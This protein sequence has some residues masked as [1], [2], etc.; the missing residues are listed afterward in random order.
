MCRWVK[1]KPVYDNVLDVC[2]RD[3]ENIESEGLQKQ[4]VYNIQT[5]LKA[6]TFPNRMCS[7][8]TDSSSAQGPKYHRDA[9]V[10]SR[11]L[12]ATVCMKLE[13]KLQN[14]TE[15]HNRHDGTLNSK[16][17]TLNKLYDG[18]RICRR[19]TYCFEHCCFDFC[20]SDN[21][22][23]SWLKKFEYNNEHHKNLKYFSKA[24]RRHYLEIHEQFNFYPKYHHCRFNQTHSKFKHCVVCQF[25]WQQFAAEK[26]SCADKTARKARHSIHIY[27]SDYPKTLCVSPSYPIYPKN[28]NSDRTE[29]RTPSKDRRHSEHWNLKRI[30][31]SPKQPP[32]GNL[33]IPHSFP[34]PVVSNGF[35]SNPNP[36][37]AHKPAITCA[38]TRSTESKIKRFSKF[39]DIQKNAR[40]QIREN[41]HSI[42][43]NRFKIQ[44]GKGNG[45]IGKGSLL[46][47]N[48][49]LHE[50][51]ET[52]PKNRSHIHELSKAMLKSAQHLLLSPPSHFCPFE[53]YTPRYS[54]GNS[55]DPGHQ[56]TNAKIKFCNG[57]MNKVKIATINIRGFKE[58]E[59][60][61][62]VMNCMDK[63]QIDI[64][65]LQ[66][67]YV[68][69]NSKMKR[70]KYTFFH[71]TDV[72]DEDRTR[73]KQIMGKGK[74]QRKGQHRLGNQ[75]DQERHGVAFIVKNSI[76]PIIEDITQIDG[77]NISIKIRDHH[78]KI[79][80]V[81][82]YAPH[83]GYELEVKEKH[84]Q[85]LHNIVKHENAH[86]KIIILGDF[87]VRLQGQ[88]ETE[89]HIIG[90]NIYGYGPQHISLCKTQVLESRELFISFCDEHNMIVSNTFTNQNN[91]HI[92]TYTDPSGERAQLDYILINNKWANSLKNIW[93]DQ[94]A[95]IYSDHKPIIATLHTKLA[96]PKTKVPFTR[97]KP[98]DNEQTENYNK[99]IQ[100]NS[101][102]IDWTDHVQVMN[103]LSD[104]AENSF[105][106][107][108]P[109]IKKSYIT[110]STWE[111]IQKRQRIHEQKEEGDGKEIVKQVKKAVRQDRTKFVIDKL[112][113]TNKKNPNWKPIKE[114]RTDYTPN[115]TK[116]MDKNGKR[117]PTNNR[118]NAIADYL[119][120][121]HWKSKDVPPNYDESP[122]HNK[123]LI[124]ETGPY[125]TAELEIVLQKT[126]GKKAP[127]PDNIQ[128]E[129]IKALKEEGREQLLILLNK[130]HENKKI[131][132][133]L[134]KATVVSIFKKGDTAK[135]ENYRPIS[136]LNTIY[137]IYSA[138][139][140]NRLENTL[141][142]II[143]KT[144]FGF[145]K[146][147]SC[148]HALH[149]I[150]RVIDYGEMSNLNII[151]IFLDW[152]KAFDKV[153]HKRLL[154]ALK[155]LN[156]PGCYLEIITN[157]YENPTFQAKYED[158]TSEYKKQEAGIRQGCT[159]SPYLFILLMTVLMHDVNKNTHKKSNKNNEHGLNENA[160]LFADDT[161]L[162]ATSTIAAKALLHEV[163]YQSE[164]YGLNL[165]KQKCVYFA[166]NKNNNINFLDGEELRHSENVTYLGAKLTKNADVKEEITTRLQK[167]NATWHKLKLFWKN[168]DCTTSWKIQVYNSVIKSKLLYGLETTHVTKAQMDRLTA[169]HTKGLRNI[170][171]L[172][173]TFMDRNNTKKLIWDKANQA[174]KNENPNAPNIETM[175]ETLG[176][177]RIKFIGHILRAD[178]N[179]PVR[180]VT[181]QPSTA[182]PVY[183]IKRRIGGPKKHWTWE[184]LQMAWQ[185]IHDN[186]AP[187]LR[188]TNADMDK[189]LEAAR[190]RKF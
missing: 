173:H 117:V 15:T 182:K 110:Q 174:L 165:N 79:L 1:S 128:P 43:L 8:N 175:S 17:K 181:F 103:L 153:N 40:K 136:L 54:T 113:T 171:K 26:R 41:K 34:N 161:T 35:R 68:N 47:S 179:D 114:L 63:H 13:S 91:E 121:Q 141:E 14:D 39:K 94:Q 102:N 160:V 124:F 53:S 7:S 116:I 75:P 109:Q 172:Q 185:L 4:Y 2:S 111:L 162:I 140:K 62:Y 157:L 73:A 86:T 6:R 71:S 59:K 150:R 11:A 48:S 51:K 49:N 19:K 176:K 23:H 22:Y 126:S 77:R 190:N 58:V 155:R 70:G 188:K 144:Q 149:I 16:F 152:E 93:V 105:E 61:E 74:G 134:A 99:F 83:S 137:K 115:F 20:N 60:Q 164:F 36:N 151:T 100:D 98:P 90:N 189:I 5:L 21:G 138:L 88:L 12:P 95:G 156:I 29:N 143:S 85:K 65:A 66:E 145:R 9:A 127:G 129:L 27:P 69:T 112:E 158:Q 133:E 146:N 118:A 28:Q 42:K 52:S 33:G 142:Q 24:A 132:P 81:N 80:F 25:Q 169:F 44:W 84:F 57:Y 92:Y 119:E 184:T 125:S 159:L 170:L 139:I 76:L 101:V 178:N 67:T 123:N 180:T 64:L 168:T 106:K 96:K 46:N 89:K 18:C 147:K 45:L 78:S 38:H 97:Y 50:V 107:T 131:N 183:P 120:T 30:N 154:Q 148:A 55:A 166:M 56:P 37:Q 108:N 72:T 177:R 167:A 130:W 187:P 87:N 186:Q 31:Q 10:A 3:T 135:L 32:K 82:T 122:I 163:E 104:A